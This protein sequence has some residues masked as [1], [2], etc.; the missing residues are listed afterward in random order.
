MQNRP[1]TRAELLFKQITDQQ[2][3]AAYLEAMVNSSPPT[4]E[5]E[6]LEFKGAS[7]TPVND[8]SIKRN[9]AKTLSSFANTEGGVI[10]WG[11]DSREDPQTKVSAASGL[12]LVA[13]TG[14]LVTR[15]Q[16]LLASVT[17]PPVTAVTISAYNTQGTEGFVVCHIPLGSFRP[18]RSEE[19]KKFYIRVGDQSREPSVTW[20]RRM[21]VPEFS[22]KLI[23][24]VHSETGIN[25]MEGPADRF[26]FTLV[27]A[28]NGTAQKVHL[29]V[30]SKPQLLWERSMLNW[31]RRPDSGEGPIFGAQREIHPGETY[32]GLAFRRSQSTLPVEFHVKLFS[33]NQPALEGD[34]YYSPFKNLNHTDEIRLATLFT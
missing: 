29:L 28:G 10:I 9:W 19:I 14:A 26:A 18:H 27:N 7:R 30:R 17:D 6:Y 31:D 4:F 16:T 24:K 21:F 3:P 32:S 11:I 5:T 34:Y 8:D 15:L 12:S 25:D 33:F 20:L 2:N 23:V 22:P 13:N 1:P